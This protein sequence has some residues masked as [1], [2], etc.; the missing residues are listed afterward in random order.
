[1]SASGLPRIPSVCLLSADR[2]ARAEADAERRRLRSGVDHTHEHFA[3]LGFTV[4]NSTERQ[5]SVTSTVPDELFKAP[6][7]PYSEIDVPSTRANSVRAEHDFITSPPRG[8]PL[9]H[10]LEVNRALHLNLDSDTIPNT[11]NPEDYIQSATEVATPSVVNTPDLAVVDQAVHET[12]MLVDTLTRLTSHPER[13][14]GQEPRPSSATSVPA[15]PLAL[16][17]SQVTPREQLQHALK[18]GS[19]QALQKLVSYL[20]PLHNLLNTI[21]NVANSMRDFSNRLDHLENHSF[22]P[23][24]PEDIQQQFEMYDGRLLELEHRMDEHD[25]LHRAIDADQS[26]SSRNRPGAANV[27]DSFGSSHSLQSTSSALLQ[28]GMAQKEVAT[29]VEG[30][31]ERLDILEAAAMPSM[32]KPWEVEVILLPWGPDLRGIWFSPDE[33]MHDPAKTITQESEEWTQRLHSSNHHRSSQ[34]SKNQPTTSSSSNGGLSLTSS[35]AFSDTESGWSSEAITNWAAGDKAE[36]L[37]P[38]ACGSNN[39][40]YKRLQSRGFVRDVTF[41]SASSRDIQ[42]TLC[43]AFGGL[44]DRSDLD[45]DHK[46]TI[47]DSYPGLR[48]R[49][50]PLRKVHKESRL[51]FLT[52]A[53]M[54]NSA[55]WSAQFLAS[56]VMMRV[57]GG[58]K[59]LY[60]TQRE[61]YI[62]HHRSEEPLS[63]SDGLLWTWQEIRQLPR[64]QPDPDSQMEGNDEQC[65]PQV[66]EADAREPCWSFIEAYDVAPASTNSSFTS[67]H[68][69]PVKLSM[70]P[71]DRQWRRSITPS[72]ILRNKPPQP[73]SPLSEN[74]PIRPTP[75]RRARTFSAPMGDQ[76]PQS[77]AKRR[78]NASPVKASSIPTESWL[79]SSGTGL[80]KAK[81]RKI[82]KLSRACRDADPDTASREQEGQLIV[83]NNPTPQSREP[84]SPFYSSQPGQPGLARTN[85]D[86]TSRSQ[87]SAAVGSKPNFAYATPYSG[88]ITGAGGFGPYDN[89]GD[90]EPDDIFADDDDD[91]G[92]QSWGGVEDKDEEIGSGS[93]SGSDSSSD[94]EGG[95]NMDMDVQGSF[96]GDDSGLGSEEDDDDS[97]DAEEDREYDLRDF[98]DQEDGDEV[99]DTLLGVLQH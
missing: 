76:V 90:T 91:D 38:K 98:A 39:L 99:F 47:I 21:P 84:P 57:S 7:G 94:A 64:Y 30:I 69:A 66:P 33:P 51:R 6:H 78:F 54:H 13:H 85:S 81:R 41:K 79:T 80:S 60:V 70:R 63:T 77:S 56:G 12:K 5:A 87:R 25:V 40:V 29:E 8:G 95:A 19:P 42:T 26:S 74:H 46:N 43:N 82:A 22:N 16:T 86:A 36:W 62:Q 65:Q 53:E 14:D 83:W 92:E 75:H 59:R 10:I 17:T 34:V 52:S 55:L 97:D 18:S 23:V 15:V 50:I 61:A 4:M 35:F 37:V 44:I 68:S 28:A 3:G 20:N 9:D 88:P 24:Q 89:G 71:A 58:K 72:S 49:L 1:M 67:H 45:E 31:K 73:I 2:R 96:S 11:Y 32:A 27:T 93:D 48:A